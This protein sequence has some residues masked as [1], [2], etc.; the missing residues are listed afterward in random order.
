MPPENAPNGGE[1]K[2]EPELDDGGRTSATG[3]GQVSNERSAMSAA[4]PNLNA[5]GS[6]LL[7][8]P[9]GPA[10]GVPVMPFGGF[11][12]GAS[13]ARL[14]EGNPRVVQ[15]RQRTK[16]V[17][18][19]DTGKFTETALGPPT[20]VIITM[21]D[22]TAPA[23]HVR[24]A[25]TM[26]VTPGETWVEIFP[27][28]TG[29]TSKATESDNTSEWDGGQSAAARN[30][31]V[32]AWEQSTLLTHDLDEGTVAEQALGQPTA[33]QVVSSDSN[34]PSMNRRFV[35]VMEVLPTA[36]G[37]SVRPR[38]MPKVSRERRKGGKSTKGSGR[39]ATAGRV[40]SAQKR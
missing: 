34:A 25:D 22:Q 37:V 18:D 38:A 5:R 29:K 31:R 30:P 17:A 20:A 39:R 35:D 32:V 21:K 27:R 15:W 23:P 19:L 4:T 16:I 3:R 36:Q 8:F 12:R 40:A 11:R 7:P 26:E 28:E 13:G 14:R 1:R 33:L 24:I 9:F 10:P 2:P 6:G